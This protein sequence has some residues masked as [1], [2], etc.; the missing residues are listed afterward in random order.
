MQILTKKNNN[1]FANNIENV[2]PFQTLTAEYIKH[3][4]IDLIRH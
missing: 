1:N 2:N 3:I 4:I